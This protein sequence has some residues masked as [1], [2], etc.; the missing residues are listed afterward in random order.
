MNINKMIK[1]YLRTLLFMF[2]VIYAIVIGKTDI[3]GELIEE[4]AQVD[5]WLEQSD[6]GE[7]KKLFR[8]Y[9][10]Y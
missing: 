6:L 7:Y 3:L 5:E 4:S 9:G 8:D 10:M 1:Q 2:V